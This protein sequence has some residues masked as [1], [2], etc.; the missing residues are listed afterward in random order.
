MQHL[1]KELR[2]SS[3]ASLPQVLRLS[4]QL[5]GNSQAAGGVKSTKFARTAGT[6]T[7][8]RS[9]YSLVQRRAWISSPARAEERK[10]FE[11]PKRIC[12][13]CPCRVQQGQDGPQEQGGDQGGVSLGSNHCISPGSFFYTKFVPRWRNRLRRFVGGLRWQIPR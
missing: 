11:A 8:S 9:Q 2:A 4:Q 7:V 10:R 12:P 1:L 6:Q 3:N 13:A 5:A